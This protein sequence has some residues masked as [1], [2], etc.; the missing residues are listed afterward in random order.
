[1]GYKQ[2]FDDVIRFKNGNLHIRWLDE[3]IEDCK[4]GKFSDIELL[5][6]SL[7]KVDTC[8]IGEQYCIDNWSMGCTL[9]NAYDDCIYLLNFDDIDDILLNGKTLILRAMPVDEYTR[10]LIKEEGY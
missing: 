3:N 4:R 5:S 2:R 1:M 8:F 9:Y 7:E 10:E 6:F